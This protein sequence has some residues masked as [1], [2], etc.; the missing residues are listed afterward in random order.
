MQV[1]VTNSTEEDLEL[2]ISW[3]ACSKQS[4]PMGAPKREKETKKQSKIRT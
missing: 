4:N 2:H 1:T 3:P